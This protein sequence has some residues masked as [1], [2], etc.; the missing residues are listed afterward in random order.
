MA[1]VNNPNESSWKKDKP[2]DSTKLG[3]NGRLT[4]EKWE[5][6][7]KKGLCL[8]CGEKGHVAQEPSR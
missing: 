4:T 6:R 2:K 3:K 8:Y 1:T 5:C 7:I